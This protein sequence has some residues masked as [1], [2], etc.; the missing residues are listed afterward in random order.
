MI[1]GRAAVTKRLETPTPVKEPSATAPAGLSL[2][3][4]R[5]A[6]SIVIAR[7]RV[8]EQRGSLHRE[9]FGLAGGNSLLGPRAGPQGAPGPPGPPGPLGPPGPP[10]PPGPTDSP[11][12]AP[13]GA[14]GPPG[15]FGGPEPGG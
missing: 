11:L 5:P 4:D 15:P 7:Q 6:G 12:G 2:A 3:R 14:S 1:R 13:P 10:G 8:F 9:A